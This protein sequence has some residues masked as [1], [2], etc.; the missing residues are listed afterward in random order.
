MN[1]LL[2]N[3]LVEMKMIDSGIAPYTAIGTGGAPLEDVIQTLSPE[4]QRKAK[5]K[6]RKM[7]RR[8]YKE[9]RIQDQ[10]RGQKPTPIELNRRKAV[11]YR[12][13]LSDVKR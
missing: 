4:E 12:M 13:I 9:F 1:S 11:V 7:W 10:R 8:A 6:F 5:R 2:S 3:I